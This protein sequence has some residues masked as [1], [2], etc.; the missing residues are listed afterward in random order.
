MS[1]IPEKPI[2]KLF[3]LISVDGKI[4]TGFGIDRSFDQDL[5]KL[6]GIKEGLQQYYPLQAQL[7]KVIFN[8]GKMLAKMGANQFNFNLN[9][10]NTD[11]VVIDNSH[12]TIQ[13]I[14]NLSRGC[15]RLFFELV[16]PSI[17]CIN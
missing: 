12:L 10:T 4:S 2:T 14:K 9:K 15:K 3:L 8:S 6:D 16:I 17:Q 11:L 5:P 7:Q 1:N 13:G